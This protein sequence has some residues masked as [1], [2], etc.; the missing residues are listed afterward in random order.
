MCWSERIERKFTFRVGKVPLPGR[1]EI[2]SEGGPIKDMSVVI[3]VVMPR[4][5]KD[6]A[7]IIK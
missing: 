1:D 3:C 2:G 5:R 6:E 7:K 4:P